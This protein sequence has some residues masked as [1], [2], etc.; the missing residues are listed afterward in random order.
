M[1]D[2]LRMRLEEDGDGSAQ[3]F[4]EASCGPFSG[5]GS[6]WFAVREVRDFGRQLQDTFPIPA[7]SPIE[8]EGGFWSS[9]NRG[10]LEERHV[11]VRIYPI[12]SN[13]NIGVRVSLATPIH[14]PD[15]A[16]A[17]SSVSFELR[18][19]YEALRSFGAELEA[20]AVGRSDVAE[21]EGNAS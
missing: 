12:G 19:H 5:A 16:E 4:V 3:L 18:T 11:G 9:T 7:E 21:L 15:R 20:L 14:H 6:A 2:H 17:Q 1:T 13:G 10:S 8:M